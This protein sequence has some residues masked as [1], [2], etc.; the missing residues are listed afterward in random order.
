MTAQNCHSIDDLRHVAMRRIPR[1]AFD[2]LEG[3]AGTEATLDR[4]RASLSSL[5]LNQYGLRDVRDRRIAVEL[6]GRT[7]SKPFGIA[8]IGLCNLVWPGADAALAQAASDADCPYV[9]SASATTEI[10]T[11]APIAGDRFWFQLY[12]S[13]REE[14]TFDLIA[15]ARAAEAQVLVV[16]IDLPVPARRLRDLRN[17]FSLPFRLTPRILMDFACHPGWC[18]ATASAGAPRFL[19]MERYMPTGSDNKSLAA[20]MAE[21]STAGL[22]AGLFSRIRDAWPGTLVVKGVLSAETARAAIDLGADGLI[23]SN[24]GG[25]QLDAV[26]ATIDVLPEIV[27]QANGAVPVMIDSGIRTG[28]DVI[29][30]YALGASYVFCG[31]PFAYGHAAAG[32]AG[33]ARA[34]EL[35]GDETDRG[36]GQIGATG[37]AMLDDNYIRKP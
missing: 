9:M 10:E 37:L 17:G 4:N 35:I 33:I 32:P 1:L 26:P 6:F 29:R 28:L 23:V 13:A 20:F 31:R 19:N 24:H 7:Y 21:Q 14:V 18:L 11:L 5:L 25:R 16:T 2:F 15:R 34:I 3:G 27:S 8:P 12:V 36:L 22:D 30:A